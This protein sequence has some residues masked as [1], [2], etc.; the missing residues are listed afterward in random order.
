MLRR[1]APSIAR[2]AGLP[3]R[4][5]VLA[6]L[7][8]CSDD[9]RAPLQPAAAPDAAALSR[10]AADAQAAAQPPG[11]GKKIPDQYIVVLRDG[12]SPG[13]AARRHGVTPLHTYSR[14]LNGFAARMTAGQ[15]Q[16]LARDP[17]V[18][19]VTQDEEV[20]S[21]DATSAAA[22][23]AGP[24]LDVS[25]SASQ[26]GAPWG[27]DRIDQRSKVLSGT[28]GY[29]ARGAGVRVYVISSGIRY[30]HVEFDGAAPNRAV[31][32]WDLVD[33]DAVAQDCYG[34]GTVLAGIIGGTTYGVAK[35]ATLVGVR[36]LGC[37]GAGSWAT[38]IAGIDW[39]INDKL[40][41]NAPAVANLS[42]G[43]A[44]F[45]PV[46]DAVANLAYYGIVPVVGAGSG[47]ADACTISPA[48]SPL[49]V[50]VGATDA[51]D[52]R[53]AFSNFGPC[54]DLF[55]P[56][57]NIPSAFW[58]SDVA[59]VVW[60]GT[61]EAAPHVAGAAAQIL[62]R[63]P[64]A[65]PG[66]V[67]EIL[68][69]DASAGLVTNAG[70]GSP[71]L[72][73]RRF[74]GRLAAAGGSQVQPDGT[75]YATAGPGNH[76]G[77]VHSSLPVQLFLDRWSGAAWVQVA[78]TAASTVPSINYAAGA[79]GSFRYRVVNPQLAAADYDLFLRRP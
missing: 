3:A 76:L 30:T 22:A 34:Q 10:A 71:N 36:V 73:L 31:S 15:A 2:A 11:R 14:A 78:A 35:A 8:A 21:T 29:V 55:A 54:L 52:S 23:G 20:R 70:A 74:N 26:P 17:E 25:V 47:S 46:D 72:L 60:S 69:D 62:G 64:T 6:A 40:A 68:R 53:P 77:Y 42:L 50:T 38:V 12:A 43:G 51:G 13:D 33:N 24:A 19:A 61:G 1:I 65:T 39:V 5:A 28:Y 49:A 37:T 59:T 9:A 57:V 58:T 44:K 16:K 32:G 67:A 66:L 79:G 63:L 75:S 7:A 4:F 56:G 18:A 41:R 45:Q 48:A 27:L